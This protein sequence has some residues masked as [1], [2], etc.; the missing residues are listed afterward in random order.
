MKIIVGV[1]EKGTERKSTD[2]FEKSVL[3]SCCLY[4]RYG[5]LDIVTYAVK[6]T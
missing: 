4:E 6:Y 5:I 3:V 1:M 2:S